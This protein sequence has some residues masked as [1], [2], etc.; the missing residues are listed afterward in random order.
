MSDEKTGHWLSLIRSFDLSLYPRIVNQSFGRSF[1]Y[2]LLLS[3]V[4]SLLLSAKYTF[5]FKGFVTQAK[6]WV[7]ANI[8]EIWP[9]GLSEVKIENG[10]VSSQTQQPFTYKR[11]DFVF[12]LDTTAKVKSLEEY[13]NGILV[14]KNKVIVKTRKSDVESEL[15]EYDLS[16]VQSFLIRQGDT[17]KGIIA[18][19]AS[20]K[21]SFSLSLGL[22]KPWF[23]L[24]YAGVFS[25][26]LIWLFIYYLNAKI[27]FALAF[28]VF[29]LIVNKIFKAGL[30]YAKLLNICF[31]ALTPAT[32]VSLVIMLI[33]TK[34][35]LPWLLHLL[36]FGIYLVLGI[37][38]V[39]DN[40]QTQEPNA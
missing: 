40:P 24:I 33:G 36:L 27:I 12:I 10:L 13:K 37:K 35:P 4:L 19:V 34:I 18:E 2:L 38:S 16:K 8:N 11:G 26:L 5:K 7:S 15:K 14:T 32:A 6:V 29:A 21:K 23:K 22:L 9:K 25:G 17:A 31:Y 20:G 28:A 1:V 30:T 39:R 3:F